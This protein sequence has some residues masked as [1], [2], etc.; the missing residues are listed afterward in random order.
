MA[1]REASAKNQSLPGIVDRAIQEIED[2][3]EEYASLRD[4][5]MALNRDES[6]CKEKLRG[7]MHDNKKKSY[8]RG[9]IEVE[10]VKET[11]EEQVKVRVR[12]G[13]DDDDN[14]AAE[15]TPELAPGEVV[16]NGTTH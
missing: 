15:T 1:K 7:L 12:K 3:A 11:V 6:A 8:K 5:R 16:D 2:A 9:R 4:Q 10:L 13:D 14:E